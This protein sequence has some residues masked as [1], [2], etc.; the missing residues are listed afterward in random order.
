MAE[1]VRKNHCG[2]D[3][4]TGQSAAASFIDAGDASDTDG[5]QSFLV[6]KTAA[7]IHWR[8]SNLTI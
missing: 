2:G 4:R 6:T 8:M 3:D 1:V 7:A 5:P